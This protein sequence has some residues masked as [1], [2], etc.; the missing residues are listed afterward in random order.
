MNINA[1]QLVLLVVLAVGWV[2]SAFALIA[3]I[4]FTKREETLISFGTT[5]F[6]GSAALAIAD[7]L[8]PGF[9]LVPHDIL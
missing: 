1:V 8:W 2:A 4:L 5:F 9:M 6:V 3:Y 7:V